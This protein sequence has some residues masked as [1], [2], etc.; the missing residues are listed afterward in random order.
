MLDQIL[1]LAGV[2]IDPKKVDELVNWATAKLQNIETLQVA[3]VKALEDIAGSLR[4]IV[5]LSKAAK[6]A[7]K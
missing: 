4:D 6:K 2:N 1:K 5:E 3:K 7:A